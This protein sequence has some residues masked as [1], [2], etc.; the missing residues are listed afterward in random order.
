MIF[1]G[2]PIDR[3][4]KMKATRQ[5]KKVKLDEEIKAIEAEIERQKKEK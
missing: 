5:A 3:L 1:A 4:E 2:K